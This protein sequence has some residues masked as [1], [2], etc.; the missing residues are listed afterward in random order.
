MYM[1][2]KLSLRALDDYRHLSVI[3]GNHVFCKT[4]QK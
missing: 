3:D 1:C 4:K 2:Y